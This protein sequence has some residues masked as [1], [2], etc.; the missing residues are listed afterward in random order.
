MTKVIEIRVPDIGDFTDIPVVEVLVKAG[1]R[2]D[3]EQSL[4]T[5]E[6]EKAIMEIPS[7]TAGVVRSIDVVEGDFVS[8]SSLIAVLDADEAV[9][10]AESVS[11]PAAQT[12]NIADQHQQAAMPM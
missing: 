9:A 3:A 6:S 5:L 1:D 7:P 11:K 10:V 4:V 12:Q 8:E 2:V